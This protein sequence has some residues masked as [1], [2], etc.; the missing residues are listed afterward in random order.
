M[1]KYPHRYSYACFS[2]S[3]YMSITH[4]YVAHYDE[5]QVL[6]NQLQNVFYTNTC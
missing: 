2:I 5:T 1:K 4:F 6:V 3:L